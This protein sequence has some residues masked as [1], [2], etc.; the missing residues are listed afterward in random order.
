MVVDRAEMKYLH[1]ISSSY[2]LAFLMDAP[3]LILVLA[4]VIY[5]HL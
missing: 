5:K 2:P 4:D 1:C 3:N